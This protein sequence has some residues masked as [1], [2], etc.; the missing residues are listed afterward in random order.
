MRRCS[1]T[2]GDSIATLSEALVSELA[3]AGKTGATAESCTG[4][5]IAKSLTDIAGSSACFAYGVVT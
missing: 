1:V 4:G 2:D 5:W 3:E